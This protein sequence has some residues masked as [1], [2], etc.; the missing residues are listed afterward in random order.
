MSWHNKQEFAPL[1][2]LAFESDPCLIKLAQD[3]DHVVHQHDAT[4]RRPEYLPLDAEHSQFKVFRLTT[5]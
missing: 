4:L 3:G 2:P 1:L 5:G